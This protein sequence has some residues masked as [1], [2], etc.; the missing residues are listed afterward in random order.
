MKNKMKQNY[1]KKKLENMLKNTENNY[2][3]LIKH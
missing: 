3:N 1:L 2:F